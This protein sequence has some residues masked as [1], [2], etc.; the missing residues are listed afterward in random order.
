MPAVSFDAP[1]QTLFFVPDF[2][3]AKKLNRFVSW[4]RGIRAGAVLRRGSIVADILWADGTEEP[5]T[6]PVAGTIVST[7]RRILHDD[8][9]RKP[10]Q[11]G[12]VLR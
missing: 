11:V 9:H 3:K 2:F 8:L 4:R 12:L 1:T 10:P 5:I 6:S 7:N